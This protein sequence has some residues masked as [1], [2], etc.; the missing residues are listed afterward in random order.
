MAE[1]LISPE[2]LNS[3]ISFTDECLTKLETQLI[4][5][6]PN[7][8]EDSKLRHEIFAVFH[9]IK[10]MGGSFNYPLMTSAGTSICRYLRLLDDNSPLDKNLIEAHVKTMRIIMENKI[11]GSGD[12]TGTELIN[13]LNELVDH[14]LA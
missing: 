9:D 3:Y 13:R 12:T 6:N 4:S 10:G 5:L 14:S 2:L 1:N 11:M 7:K 8:P